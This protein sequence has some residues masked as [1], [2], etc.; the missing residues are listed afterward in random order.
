MSK[1]S[2]ESKVG[3]LLITRKEGEQIAINGGELIIEVVEIQ[4]SRVRLA[5]QA[6]RD[7]KIQRAEEAEKERHEGSSTDAGKGR[8]S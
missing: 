3:G 1:F 6:P 4:A 7:I 2:K 5:F 8:T